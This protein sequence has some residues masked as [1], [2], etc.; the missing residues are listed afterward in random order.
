MRRALTAAARAAF[1]WLA[2]AAFLA[3]FALLTGCCAYSAPRYRGPRSD[4]FDGRRFYTPGAR[5]LD[6]GAVARWLVT[7]HRGPWSE[8]VTEPSGPPPPARVTG[9][10]IRVTFV[11]HSTLLVQMDGVNVLT[12]PVWSDRVGPVSWIGPK[13]HRPPGV[14][15][16]DLPHIDAVVV[17]H[18]HY[19]HLDLP[20]LASLASAYHPPILT[21]LGNRAL[22][23]NA[24]VHGGIDLDWWQEVE[25]GPSVRVIAVPAQ[26]A[27]MRGLCD[28]DATLWAG[29]VITGPSGRVFFAGDTGYG[30]HFTALRERLGPMR[31]A[32]LPIGSSKPQEVLAP[33]HMSPADALRAHRDLGA[34][35]SVAMHFGTFAQADDGED[36]PLVDLERALDAAP[37]R[38][39]F[40]VLGQGE[41]RAVP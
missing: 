24:G 14:R 11:N 15:F 41:G 8:R 6:P 22:L 35:T 26:H 20:T 25:I 10:D 27:S 33:V 39:R 28:R 1:V 7:R 21:G 9:G 2:A 38:P 40:W 12:D 34:P 23:E 5:Q 32:L 31:V 19:D 37:V 16:A 4:H 17:S 30:P 29:F 3:T 36:E 13:R 18:N